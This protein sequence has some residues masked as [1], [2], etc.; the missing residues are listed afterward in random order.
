MRLGAIRVQV[1]RMLVDVEAA[2]LG[3]RG[4][5]FGFEGKAGERGLLIGVQL[6][7]RCSVFAL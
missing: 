5:A 6:R 3:D 7:K 1:Q 4:L 2:F